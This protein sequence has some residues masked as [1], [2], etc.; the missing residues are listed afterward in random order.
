MKGRKA[1]QQME[2][3]IS[4]DEDMTYRVKPNNEDVIRN[5]HTLYD[6]VCEEPV[7]DYLT[8]LLKKLPV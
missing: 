5:L 1:N 2:D 3:H 4:P 8:D 7:P 6:S